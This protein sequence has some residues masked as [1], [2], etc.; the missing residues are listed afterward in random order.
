MDER[1]AGNACRRHG[2]METCEMKLLTHDAKNVLPWCC[3]DITSRRLLETMGSTRTFYN[4]EKITV[5]VT[6][7]C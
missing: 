4:K 7:V 6:V 1:C 2:D 3:S 5:V